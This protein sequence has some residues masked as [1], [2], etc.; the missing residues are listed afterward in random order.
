[1]HEPRGGSLTDQQRRS[2]RAIEEAPAIDGPAPA[3]VP[4]TEAS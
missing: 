2:L 3:G 1:M 4:R